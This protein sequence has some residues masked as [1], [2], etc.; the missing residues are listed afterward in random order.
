MYRLNLT[1][2]Q[3]TEVILSATFHFLLERRPHHK[4]WSCKRFKSLS[5]HSLT[6]HSSPSISLILRS[7]SYGSEVS[8]GPMGLL[9]GNMTFH[10]QRRG[11]WQMKDVT[12]VIKEA[13]NKGHLLVSVELDIGQRRPEEVES[14][15][16]LPYLLLYAE[17]R[18]LAEPNSVAASL[19]RYDPLGEGEEPE[20]LRHT[21]SSPESKGRMRREVSLFSD[22]IENNELPEVDYRTEGY[23]KDD[24]WESTWYLALK[25]K[26]NAEKKHNRRQNQE[27]ELLK[28]SRVPDE[29]EHVAVKDGASQPLNTHDSGVKRL[30]GAWTLAATDSLKQPKDG[31][32]HKGSGNFQSP[33]LSF[34]ERTMRKARRRQWGDEQHRGCS[35]RNLRVDF[36]DIGWSEWVIAPKAFDAYYCAGMC[37]FP[38]PRVRAET[39]PRL[40]RLICLYGH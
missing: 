25:P 24:L 3:D 20:L 17:D 27:E 35:R 26:H 28:Q 13:Q 36:A 39:F 33:V 2:L 16:S 6:V 29:K 11:V 37:G 34:D 7:I 32:K 12:Q 40:H 38:I 30:K 21:D 9:L 1:S 18:A 22:P 10:P 5:C 15:N 4:S 23:R 14:V 8:H 31:K 19:Q